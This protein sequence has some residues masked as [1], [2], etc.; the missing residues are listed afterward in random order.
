[1]KLC[2]KELNKKRPVCNM[3]W[4]LSL[5]HQRIIYVIKDQDEHCMCRRYVIPV[6]IF[7]NREMSL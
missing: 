1:V 4:L 2:K 6:F 5:F 3:D 7:K